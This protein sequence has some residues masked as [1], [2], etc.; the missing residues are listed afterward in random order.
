MR[1]PTDALVPPHELVLDFIVEH[2]VLIL[3]I[4]AAIAAITVLIV[5]L[6]KRK[7]RKANRERK[8]G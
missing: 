5:V 7:K 8:D 4:L 2:R 6:V 1:I 3:G